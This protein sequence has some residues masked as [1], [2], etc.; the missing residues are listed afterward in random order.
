MK[1]MKKLFKSEEGV[2]RLAYR[3]FMRGIPAEKVCSMTDVP[4]ASLGVS[5][6]GTA[7]GNIAFD[8]YHLV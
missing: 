6:N 8:R 1:K 5:V 2:E 3:M 4:K 7:R